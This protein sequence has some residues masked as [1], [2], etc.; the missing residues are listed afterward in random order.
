MSFIDAHAHHQENVEAAKILQSAFDAG[1]EKIALGGT[2]PPDWKS[3]VLLDFQFPKKLFLHFGL[4]PW[5]VEKYTREEIDQILDQLDREL[6]LVSRLGETG[7]DFFPE[8]RAFDISTLQRIL[9]C[10]P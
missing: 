3:Q 7:L 10:I 8:K 4:H 1:I 2:H 9:I 6:P 5:W